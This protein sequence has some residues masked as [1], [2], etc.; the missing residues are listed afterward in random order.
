VKVEQQ[1]KPPWLGL[2]VR[3]ESCGL[4]ASLEASDRTSVHY[5]GTFWFACPTC[6]GSVEIS[7]PRRRAK[8]EET[9]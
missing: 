2:T 7:I 4:V 6:R 1:G 8:E 3:C 5:T 9:A